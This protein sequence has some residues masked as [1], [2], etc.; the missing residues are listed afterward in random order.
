MQFTKSIITFFIL[1]SL[2]SCN[3][4]SKDK[5]QKEEEIPLETYFEGEIKLSESRGYQGSLFKIYTTYHISENRIKREQKAKGLNAVFNM[6]NGIIIDLTTDS[7]ILYY[8]D[9]FQKNKHTLTVKE[10]DT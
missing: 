5:N 7:I 1:S 8:S 2:M 6:K 10:Y 9:V 3:F 4:F